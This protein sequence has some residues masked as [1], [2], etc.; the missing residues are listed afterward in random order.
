ML[1]SVVIAAMISI[2]AGV[3]LTVASKKFAVQVNEK[4]EEVRELLPGANCGACG[5]AGCD[6]YAKNLVEYGVKTNLCVPGGTGLARQIS[7][8]LGLPFEEVEPR[9]A[10]VKCSGT[11]EHTSYIMDYQG[12]KTCEACNYF[13]RGRGSCSHSCLGLGDCVSVCRYG[14]L[15]IEDNVAVVNK[16][17][18]VACGLC[19]GVCPNHLIQ[20]IPFSSQVFVGCSSTDTGAFVRKLCT[21]GCIGCKKCEKVCEFG[22]ITITN[23]LANIDPA[24]CT[25]CAACVSACPTGIIHIMDWK[26]PAVAATN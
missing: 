6:D 7:Q 16:A 26:H 14:A 19:V 18:C 25:N 2:V 11:K 24:K 23:N 15:T 9:Y 13:Y 20:I 3:V 5:F 1:L 10:V 17:L 12:P 22:A 8:V 4:V 21:A